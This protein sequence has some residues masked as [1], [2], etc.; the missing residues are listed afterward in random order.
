MPAQ[1]GIRWPSVAFAGIE[2]MD[3]RFRGNDRTRK[4]A[5]AK[6]VPV[7][8]N[9]STHRHLSNFRRRPFQ[10]PD[11]PRVR[12]YLKLL[13][14]A[15]LQLDALWC[16]AGQQTSAQTAVFVGLALLFEYRKGTFLHASVSALEAPLIQ[17]TANQSGVYVAHTVP[18]I[19]L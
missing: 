8:A 4:R 9:G 19:V 17:R 3:S 11:D 13:A 1:A 15:T 16:N 18:Q 6:Y 2:R 5:A 10:E 7:V 14:L 12:N